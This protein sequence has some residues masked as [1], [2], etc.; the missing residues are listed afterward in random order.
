MDAAAV[1][2]KSIIFRRF[3][4]PDRHYI[5]SIRENYTGSPKNY[6]S[7]KLI[8]ITDL[9]NIPFHLNQEGASSFNL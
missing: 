5:D 7:Y 9:E 4:L 3:T 2:R 8:T 6:Y 1:P